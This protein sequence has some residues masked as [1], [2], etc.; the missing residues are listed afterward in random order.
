MYKR[1]DKDVPVTVVFSDVPT[2]AWYAAAVNTLASLGIVNG[3]GNSQF[4]P[5]RPIT[6]AEF[7]VIALSLIH[8]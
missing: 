2:D 4:A 8:I 3:V 5:D 1:Q 6:R 7:T